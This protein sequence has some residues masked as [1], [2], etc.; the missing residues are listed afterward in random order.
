MKRC[1]K[2]NRIETDDALGFCRM[3]GTRLIA[4]A[5]VSEPATAILP[6]A[7]E[8]AELTTGH[9]QGVP[10]VAVLPFVN[11]SADPENEYFCD[12]LA[13][14]LLNALA[15]I[16]DLKVA[17]R[18]S[19][20]SFKG[21]NVSADEIG[22]TLHVKTVLEGSVRKSGNRLRI[23]VQLVNAADGYHLWSERY[24]REMKDV[25]DV[26]DEITLAVV[27]ALKLR[28]LGDAREEVLKRHTEDSA[29]YQAYLEGRF[30]WY[31]RSGD[32]LNRSIECFNRALKIDPGY[33]LAHL[34]LADSYNILGFYTMR[35]PK[36]TFPQ[37]KT[38]ALKAL[39]IDPSLAEA[40]ASI[41]Y[42]QLYHEWDWAAAETNFRHAIALKPDYAIAHQYYGNFLTLMS[43]FDEALN[44]FRRTIQLDPLSLIGN[45]A[46]GWA[47]HFARQYDQSI[48]QLRK[49][50]ELDRNFELAHFWLGSVYAEKEMF[51]EAIHELDTAVRL[52]GNRAGISASLGYV[53][54]LAG[55]RA[56]ALQVLVELA[57]VSKEKYVSPYRIAN[58]YTA[59][60]DK[61]EAFIWLER[62]YDDRSHLLVFLNVDPRVDSLRGDARFVD[63][64][65]RVGLPQ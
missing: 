60:G 52:S 45:A 33:A 31:K 2:C 5:D 18:T 49:A 46:L 36:E 55:E 17:A 25:F 13:E 41:A 9:L 21:K 35:P 23:T 44:E 3:D 14:E 53:Y 48:E 57:D 43:R 62:A 58:I 40:Q 39:E 6:G 42:V 24:D 11:M 34:G 10:S 59:L 32:G 64:V 63:L 47:Y 20:F 29:A 16:D 37:A 12:G 1:P 51:T 22:H 27:D 7:R 15:K 38:A 65:R 56:K 19:S 30:Y 54:A 50:I 4:D 28:L 8:N 61:D 26:Q